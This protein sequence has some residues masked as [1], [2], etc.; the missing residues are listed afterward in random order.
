MT[1]VKPG[2]QQVG[3]DPRRHG[4][5]PFGAPVLAGVAE[6]G[7]DG[8]EARRSGAP[9]RI[10]EEHE[11]E[12]VHFER[13]RRRLDQVHVVAADAVTHR[14]VQLPVGEAVNARRAKTHPGRL[15]DRFGQGGVGRSGEKG[16]RQ[17]YRSALT[18]WA[19]ARRRRT[20][21]SSVG[22]KRS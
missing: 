3:D 4:L 7:D 15:G 17:V 11:L 13:R 12:E 9:A 10:G 6:V 22:S 21:S 1:R 8:G 20:S 19:A 18:A 2:R 5:S 16:E 14:Y